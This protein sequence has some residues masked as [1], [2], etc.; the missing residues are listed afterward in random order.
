MTTM[1]ITC[2]RAPGSFNNAKLNKELEVRIMENK[3]ISRR[4]FMKS[5]AV[6]ASVLVGPGLMSKEVFAAGKKRP[7]VVLIVSDDHGLDAVGCYG[8]PVIK[9]EGKGPSPTRV[10]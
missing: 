6:G 8:N 9:T 7:N 3:S 2:Y 1:Q 5:C 4:D 10:E